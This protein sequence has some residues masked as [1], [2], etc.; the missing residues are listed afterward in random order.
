MLRV[1]IQADL[2]PASQVTTKKG[3]SNKNSAQL[4]GIAQIAIDLVRVAIRLASRDHGWIQFT[5]HD[6]VEQF[7]RRSVQLE[8][9]SLPD[10][11]GAMN[12]S[13]ETL[14]RLPAQ[15][16]L[17][18]CPAS[19]VTIT[20]RKGQGVFQHRCAHLCGIVQLVGEG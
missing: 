20:V 2:L 19:L 17:H 16:P 12:T 7:A 8:V 1:R 6:L 11:F 4:T 14:L 5:A 18:Q 15:K 13:P 3:D 10:V 9:L